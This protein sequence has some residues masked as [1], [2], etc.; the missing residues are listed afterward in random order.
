MQGSMV[1]LQLYANQ[2]PRTNAPLQNYPLAANTGAQVW[3]GPARREA[4]PHK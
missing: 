3:L 1:I 2:M 4:T